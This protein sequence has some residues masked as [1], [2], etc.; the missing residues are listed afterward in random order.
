M[1]SPAS[2]APRRP[3]GLWPLA[4]KELRETL[5]DRRTLMT[6]VVMP[7]LVYPLMSVVMQRLLFS[8]AGDY[9]ADPLRLGFVSDDD[10]SRFYAALER[11]DDVYRD[12]VGQTAYEEEAKQSGLDATHMEAT[13]VEDLEQAVRTGAV[14]LGVVWESGDPVRFRLLRVPSSARG[15][16]AAKFVDVRFEALR[17]AQVREVLARAK[18]PF[19]PPEWTL[20]RVRTKEGASS[21]LAMIVPIILIMMTITG[22][23]Y[24]SIDLTAGE[25]ER[26]TMEILMASPAPRLYLLLAKYVAVVTVAA[27]TATVNLTALGVT[28]W[29]SPAIRTL[30]FGERDFSFATFGLVFLFVVL[31]AAFFSS[32]LLAVTSFA[33]SFKEAQAYLIPLMIAALAPALGSMLPGLSLTPTL[34]LAPVL[35]VTLLARDTLEGTASLPATAVTILATIFY[36]AAALGLAAKC[37][38]QDGFLIGGDGTFDGMLHRADRPTRH[39]S[40]G[41]AAFS[42]ALLFPMQVLLATFVSGAIG[43]ASV[44]ANLWANALV[45]FAL[46]AILPTLWLVWQRV[47]PAFEFRFDARTLLFVP[48]LVLLALSSWIPAHESIVIGE[49]IF[50]SLIS[51]ETMERAAGTVEKMRQAPLWLV[52]VTIAFVPAVAEELY[53]RGF[54]LRSLRVRQ[55]AWQATLFAA[56]AFGGFHVFTAAFLPERFVPTA[57]LGLML[58]YV[59]CRTRNLAASA[60]VHFAHN[61]LVLTASFYHEQL[62]DWGIGLGDDVAADEVA[63]LPIGWILAG[64]IGVTLGI[65]AIEVARRLGGP[66]EPEPSFAAPSDHE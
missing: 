53:F 4:L 25:R 37:F 39:P 18:I 46:F 36:G 8:A 45:T 16:A 17:D 28:A 42:L 59:Y 10:G 9:G 20:E 52:L 34:A 24:P 43:G 5:R 40:A 47:R 11:A 50:G 15:E 48:G 32:L 6:L 57:L 27:L 1:S 14:D 55:G 66:G 63:H 38:E 21:P 19:Q 62:A 13:W 35:N 2:A 22:A 44:E 56:L 23:V 64:V 26:G 12:A 29:V 58:G 54:L 41:A 60:A 61:G 65:A 49:Q 3:V 30:L 31:F 7:L 33:R 51:E